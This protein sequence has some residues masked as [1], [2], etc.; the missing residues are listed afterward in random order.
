MTLPLL[1]KS[2]N[3]QRANYGNVLGSLYGYNT[4]RAVAG[5]ILNEIVLV[6]FLV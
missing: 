1:V 2:L 6:R 3:E 4:M 5:V